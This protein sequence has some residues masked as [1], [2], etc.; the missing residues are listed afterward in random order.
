MNEHILFAL[1]YPIYDNKTDYV[2]GEGGHF[3]HPIRRFSFGLTC[4]INP[5][6]ERPTWLVSVSYWTESGKN[7]INT[8]NW[9]RS[10][11]DQAKRLR[12][13]VTEDI[14]TGDWETSPFANQHPLTAQWYKPMTMV[15]MS[16]L[17]KKQ[18]GSKINT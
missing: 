13:Q 12:D 10:V 6:W 11:V 4:E 5:A 15:E 9:R 16:Q 8:S 2:F 18:W 17:G 3:W 7:R 14:G 1:A